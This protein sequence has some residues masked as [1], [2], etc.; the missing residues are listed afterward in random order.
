MKYLSQS[1]KELHLRFSAYGKNAKEWLRK[2]ALL[3][4]EIERRRIWK[5]RG[6]GSIYEYAAKLAGMSRSSV[7]EALRVLKRIEDKP[8]LKTVVEQKGINCVRPVAAIAT[9][10][11]QEFWAEKVQE[12]SKHTLEN[13]VRDYR[14]EFLP[15]EEPKPAKES[16]LLELDPEIA[17]ELKKLKGDNEWSDL[18]R[19]FLA[20]RKEKFEQEKPE[21]A[22][23][24]SRH[25]PAKIDRHVRGLTGGRCAFPGCCREG[26]VLHHIQRF[27]SERVHDPDKLVFLCKAH[28]EMAH[29]GLIANENQ[30]PDKWKLREVADKT[31]LEWWVDDKVQFYRRN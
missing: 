13:Y 28:H 7:D 12:M 3:L 10:E 18:M 30:A 8:A 26:E 5:K 9:E 4:P 17:Q 31:R 23:G 1:E 22:Q 6:F 20:L 14:K 27:S 24:R 15:G 25:I 11:T 2:C 16:I 29:L 21:V 19:E